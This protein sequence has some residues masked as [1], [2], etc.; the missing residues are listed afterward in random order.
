MNKHVTTREAMR[1]LEHFICIEA[2]GSK[3]QAKKLHL[4]SFTK[5]K[6]KHMNIPLLDEDDVDLIEYLKDC[7]DYCIHF[8]GKPVTKEDL[9]QAIFDPEDTM[10]MKNQKEKIVAL[11]AT[12]SAKHQ[13]AFGDDP[14]QPKSFI[15]EPQL[16][17]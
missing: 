14:L 12:L 11:L 7:G 8:E 3:T 6:S 5:L 4:N 13:V 2:A 10:D 17:P 15:H 9:L 1:A 16:G